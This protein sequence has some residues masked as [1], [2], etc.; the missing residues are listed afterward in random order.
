MVEIICVDDTFRIDQKEYWKKHN[1]KHPIKDEIYTIR[2]VIKHTNGKTGIMLN[3]IINPKILINHP[4][5]GYSKRETTWNIDRF[6]KLNGDIISK[7]ELE[8]IVSTVVEVD[9]SQL[10]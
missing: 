5:L 8:N 3:E 10:N 9:I 6:R 1:V 2:D 7:E 4:I